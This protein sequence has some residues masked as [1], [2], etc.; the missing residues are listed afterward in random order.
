MTHSERIE[1]IARAL[2][3]ADAEYGG[4]IVSHEWCLHQARAAYLATLESLREPS[5]DMKR[6]AKV[7]L[8]ECEEALTNVWR[9]MI[10]AAIKEAIE[11]R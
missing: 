3:V 8:W 9:A 1:R 11:C 4:D 10:D 2:D 6:E 7:E 5:E